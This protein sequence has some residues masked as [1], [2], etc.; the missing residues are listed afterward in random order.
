MLKTV[1]YLDN[2]VAPYELDEHRPSDKTI[3]LKGLATAQ[4]RQVSRTHLFMHSE[5]CLPIAGI[6]HAAVHHS[7][8]QRINKYNIGIVS[9]KPPRLFTFIVEDRSSLYALAPPSHS[10]KVFRSSIS[11]STVRPQ[12]VAAASSLTYSPMHLLSLGLCLLY[13]TR[14][15]DAAPNRIIDDEYGDAVTGVLPVYGSGPDSQWNFGP[16]CSACALRPDADK[17]FMR[18]WHDTTAWSGKG[19]TQNITL[20]FQGIAP[21]PLC[22]IVSVC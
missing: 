14:N 18:T 3:T 1:G 12:P 6:E 19:P 11:S 15:T 16:T 5:A 17:L 4:V 13:A 8:V 9:R 22:D 21:H 2:L 10:L 7:V 20:S